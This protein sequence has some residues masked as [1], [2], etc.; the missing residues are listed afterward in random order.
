[1]ATAFAKP[2][3]PPIPRPESTWRK[4][5]LAASVAFST[6]FGVAAFGATTKWFGGIATRGYV[7]QTV[8]SEVSKTRK[9]TATEV[10]TA[11]NASTEAILKEVRIGNT[12]QLERVGVEIRERVALQVALHVGMDPARA[13]AALRA[14]RQ[15][16]AKWDELMWRKTR[17]GEPQLTAEQVEQRVLEWA[18][19]PR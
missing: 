1:M 17:D 11:I 16:Y 13:Q 15:A 8:K 4:H 18:G 7:D 9:K 12:M 3:P 5:V 19:A 14:K 6:A 10:Q 2:A